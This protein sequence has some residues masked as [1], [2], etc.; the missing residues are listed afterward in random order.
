M[1]GSSHEEIFLSFVHGAFKLHE[2][3]I[4]YVPP[5]QV[6]VELGTVS[7]VRNSLTKLPS[8]GVHAMYGADTTCQR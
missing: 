5:G 3:K 4:S 1:P 8:Q 7:N 6:L 2:R